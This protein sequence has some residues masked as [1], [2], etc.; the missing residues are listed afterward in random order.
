MSFLAILQMA[1]AT[2]VASEMRVRRVTVTGLSQRCAATDA[3]MISTS[4]GH[5]K[6]ADPKAHQV[7]ERQCVAD[8]SL[9][10][11]GLQGAS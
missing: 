5:G 2:I 9:A 1:D 10:S 6:S 7:A 4:L 8:L 11:A 3:R